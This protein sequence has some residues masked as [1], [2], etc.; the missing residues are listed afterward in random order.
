MRN[1]CSYDMSEKKNYENYIG[2]ILILHQ[3]EL[4]ENR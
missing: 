3:K 1:S 2:S 4:G